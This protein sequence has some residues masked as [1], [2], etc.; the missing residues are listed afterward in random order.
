MSRKSQKNRIRNIDATADATELLFEAVTGNSE[1]LLQLVAEFSD[2]RQVL[3]SAVQADTPPNLADSV[4][5]DSNPADSEPADSEPADSD[6]ADLA[7][8]LDL[9]TSGQVET[10]GQ[11][12]LIE[13][14]FESLRQRIEE[15]ESQNEELECDNS[16]LR[17]QNEELASK[18]ADANV[19]RSIKSANSLRSESLSW[20]ERKQLIFRQMEE[21]SFDAEAFITNT[22]Q[23]HLTE[24]ESAEPLDESAATLDPIS[25]VDELNQ[26]LDRLNRD[27]ARREREIRELNHLLEQ[28]PEQSQEGMA[29]GAAAI[30]SMVD[31]DELIQEERYRLQE[32]QVE[33]E[34]KFRQ[35]EIEASLERA[36]LSRERQEL[37][38]RTAE[39]EEQLEHMRHD[40]RQAE[41]ADG[42]S[43]KWLAKLGLAGN[44]N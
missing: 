5:A 27:L 29:I 22:I 8:T 4:L 33:W 18:V 31:S 37:I 39:L 16:E 38:K 35:T 13:C 36:K 17:R 34:E 15:L 21:D 1:L 10:S 6:P 9:E 25:Y 2:L 20:E 41:Q 28:R 32:L 24:E 12:E 7:T 40:I 26:E 19:Q 30:A 11:L 3:D 42:H 43:R 23:K 14:E 44:D